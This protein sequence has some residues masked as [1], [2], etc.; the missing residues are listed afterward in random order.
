MI[1]INCFFLVM[2]FIDFIFK[3]LCHILCDVNV[4]WDWSGVGGSV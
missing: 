2:S 1:F 4:V 3:V